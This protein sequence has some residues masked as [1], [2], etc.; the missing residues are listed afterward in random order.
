MDNRHTQFNRKAEKEY[1]SLKDIVSSTKFGK[2][3]PDVY[4][5][6]LLA[7]ICETVESIFHNANSQHDNTLL[8]MFRHLYENVVRLRFLALEPSKGAMEF[9]LKEMRGHLGIIGRENAEGDTEQRKQDRLK[10]LDI[11]NKSLCEL[12]TL[13]NTPEDK[14]PPDMTVERMCELVNMGET[15]TVYRLFSQFEH[16]TGVGLMGTVLNKETRTVAIGNQL[17]DSQVATLWGAVVVMITGTKE[18][19]EMLNLNRPA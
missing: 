11:E 5:S 4:F 1:E 8:I 14:N 19:I 2:S 16:S 7:R 6:G 17:S 9:Q 3:L 18:G 13:Y 15:Y 10:Y 12:R